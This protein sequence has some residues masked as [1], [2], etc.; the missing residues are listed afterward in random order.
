MEVKAIACRPFLPHIYVLP[1]GAVSTVGTQTEQHQSDPIPVCPEDIKPPEIPNSSHG[2]KM[3]A[4]HKLSKGW[5][6]LLLT[7]HITA[8]CPSPSSLPPSI[9]LLPLLLCLAQVSGFR[10][11][12]RQMQAAFAN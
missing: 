11:T 10:S 8:A 6:L 9:P 5:I 4:K 2:V 3:S 12:A 7:G 1:H